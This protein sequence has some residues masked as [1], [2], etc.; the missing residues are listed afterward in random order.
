MSLRRFVVHQKVLDALWEYIPQIVWFERERD[1]QPTLCR[2][3][4]SSMV[5][6]FPEVSG[7]QTQGQCGH[8]TDIP[9]N[10]LA[11]MVAV[12]TFV[13]E[14]ADQINLPGHFHS[15]PCASMWVEAGRSRW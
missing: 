9:L 14:F 1:R 6:T 7:V 11:A 13:D 8:R 4:E 5:Q 15:V 10:G 3:V 12:Q 2:H